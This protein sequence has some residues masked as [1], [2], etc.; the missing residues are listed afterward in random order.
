MKYTRVLTTLMLSASTVAFASATMA[1]DSDEGGD[2][3]IATGIRQSLENAIDEK[4]EADSLIE[5]IL[6]EDI[7]KLPDQNLAEVLENITGIQIT[8]TAGVGT[9]VQIR[10]T[11][12]N[13]TEI[14]GVSTVGAG[15]GR[16]GISFEDVSA[17]IIAGVEV[18]KSPEAGT[19][20]G[21]VGGTINLRTIRPLD[22]DKPLISARIQGENSDLSNT[23]S[24]RFSGALGHKWENAS[25]QEIGV[26]LSGSYTEQEA[27]SFRPRVD[28]DNAVESITQQDATFRTAAQD[29]P[30]LGIQFLN[31][32]LENFEFE[33]IN[34]AGSIEAKPTNNLKLYLDA[35]F[36]DQE[37]TQDSFRI[38]GSGVSSVIEVNTPTGFEEIDLGSLGG[39]DLGSIQTAVTGTIQPFFDAT[40]PEV[41]L[42]DPN[43][44]FSSDT[45]ARVTTS[46]IYRLGGEW[47][48]DGLTARAEYANTF[49]DTSSPNLSTTLNF[50]NPNPNVPSLA[51]LDGPNDNSV[52]FI[53]DLTGGSLTFGVDFA[54]PFAPTVEDLLNPNNVNL[55][56]VSVGNDM[57]ENREEAF[58]LDFSYDLAEKV[59][60]VS[61]VDA[62]YRFNET[63][64]TFD[65]IGSNFSTGSNANSPNGSLF[66]DLLVPGPDNFDEADG[67]DLAFRNFLLIDPN[68]AF[69]D[70]E[71]TLATLIDA[72]N[73]TPGGQA[74]LAE[75]DPLL[76]GP[77]SSTSAFF[78]ITEETHA[79]YAQAN[80]EYGIFSGNAGFRWLDTDVSSL[81]NSDVGGVISQVVTNGG[82][83]EFLPRVNLAV[84]PI[85][86]VLLRASWTEDI[87]RPDFTDLNTSVNFPTGPNNPVS[88][89]NPALSPET[90]TSFDVSADW[91]F[92]ES[93]LFS[94]GFFFK[95]RSDL[96]VTTIEEAFEDPTT[97]FRDITDPCEGG[98]IFNPIPDRNV[99]SD[100][101]GNGLCVPIQTTVNDTASTEQIGVEVAFQYDLSSWED[102][103]GSFDWASGFG[104]IANYTWQDFTGGQITDDP[105][106]RGEDIFFAAN[107]V[108]GLEQVRGLLDFSENA[109]NLT[110]YYEKF[111]LSARARW[112]WRDSFR[113]L[114]TAAGASLNSTLGFPTV[115]A[116]RGQ[117]NASINYDITEQIT[118]GVE[119]VNLTTSDI[120]QFCVNDNALF[121]FQGLPD[122][123]IT[124]GASFTY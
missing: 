15:T 30:F 76:E 59:P 111:G 27:T 1:Q 107:G 55:D 95:D 112:T 63:S 97:G 83:T 84:R 38:Q 53:F 92:A 67:R 18:I 119:G 108:T 121:C 69:N 45:G 57:V 82:Y 48:K 117:L 90:V 42:D 20:E 70:P 100:T 47:E 52:P 115:T 32:E 46:E 50:I 31:Q 94:I 36:N 28:R 10:G 64:S 86:D 6:A 89:G 14:N 11:D 93:S 98:G 106:G 101:I 44:R 87:L 75:G 118:I 49:S 109:Y 123:R 99:L 24:P 22:L 4:R 72:L 114:D 12:D 66:A 65:D 5:V 58:R 7:G 104:I 37:R 85:D 62:G 43:L 68:A 120:D 40:N 80:F 16:G 2:V 88:I 102:R 33:N 54:S 79:L 9:N 73:S 116:A 77:T 91:Y 110:G 105:S 21:S 60:F 78:D 29:F 17:S 96:F 19:I 81:G 23:T 124:F 25:G 8:R 71:G 35:V 34:I 51:D 122:R 74:G 41:D 13:R 3:V 39:Q 103:L 56:A 61:S 26:V 113:T